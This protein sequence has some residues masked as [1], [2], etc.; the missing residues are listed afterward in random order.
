MKTRIT[1]RQAAG[2]AAF[3][4]ALCLEVAPAAAQTGLV[5]PMLECVTVDSQTRQL[6]GYFGYKSV[7]T[8]IMTLP[9]TPEDNIFIGGSTPPS[10]G[11]PIVF[12]PGRFR[13]VF[14]A[15]FDLS[16]SPSY[17]WVLNGSILRIR[18]DPSTYCQGPVPGPP[19][20]PGPAGPQGPEGP[21]GPAGPPGP[22]GPSFAACRTV[23]R[24]VGDT[25]RR[26]Q[27]LTVSCDADEVVYSGGGS[28][29]ASSITASEPAST[30]SWRL[31]CRSRAQIRVTAV[32]CP[33]PAPFP[34]R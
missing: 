33:M 15:V 21:Q 5:V 3:A 17:S 2:L 20:P 32:C 25:D 28:C 34:K 27:E 29:P 18:D 1:R 16:E 13:S 26:P 7:A 30:A 12:I 10:L 19:G 4:A 11:Q 22:P 24:Q 14:S 31:E 8:Q 9:T 23:T 6:T